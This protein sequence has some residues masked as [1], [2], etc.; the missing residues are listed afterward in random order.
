MS[1]SL[2]IVWNVVKYCRLCYRLGHEAGTTGPECPRDT[3]TSVIQA[4]FSMIP[5]T[6]MFG[7]GPV[8]ELKNTTTG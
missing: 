6:K 8:L 4:L 3:N 7:L 1:A 5:N 2:A